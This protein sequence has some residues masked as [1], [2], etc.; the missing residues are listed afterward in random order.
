[1]RAVVQRVS[2]ASV[3]VD[4]TVKGAIGK[5]LLVLLAVEAEDGL[6]DLEWLA[7]KI[8]RLRIFSDPL[9]AMNR[10]VGDTGGDILLISQFTLLASTR[11]GNRP[12]FTRA[13]PPDIAR[14]L[15]EAFVR[16]LAQGLGRPIACGEFGA[17]MKVGLVND[18]PVTLL[19]DSRR[20]E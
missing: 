7:G 5:G 4:G 8:L 10:S 11:K 18:G 2:E 1:M 20:R 19:I 14:P 6:E 12:S 17:D 3:T 13:A 16:Q 15:C 9:G